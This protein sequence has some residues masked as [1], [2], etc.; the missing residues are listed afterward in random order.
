MVCFAY[1]T[2]IVDYLNSTHVDEVVTNENIRGKL[3]LV[4]ASQH[5]LVIDLQGQNIYL[6]CECVVLNNTVLFV[7]VTRYADAIFASVTTELTAYQASAYFSYNAGIHALVRYSA[8]A[9]AWSYS[10]PLR[11]YDFAVRPTNHIPAI[12]ARMRMFRAY[13]ILEEHSFKEEIPKIGP[14]VQ[15]RQ[16]SALCYNVLQ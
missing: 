4:F 16:D 15:V 6:S 8:F 5:P 7:F 11:V 10:R 2:L 13:D 9:L 12:A 3:R 14:L 1:P